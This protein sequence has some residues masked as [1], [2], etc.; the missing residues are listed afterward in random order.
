VSNNNTLFQPVTWPPET[1]PATIEQV[2]TREQIGEAQQLSNEWI[3]AHPRY[4]LAIQ[5]CFARPGEPEW[6][7]AE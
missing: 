4:P 6:G 2:M 5:Q 1:R 3:A 7:G